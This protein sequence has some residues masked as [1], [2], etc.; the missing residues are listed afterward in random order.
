V[1][2]SL[3]AT[4]GE[5]TEKLE[6]KILLAF[7]HK[8]TTHMD[9]VQT[10]IRK[11]HPQ[12]EVLAIDLEALEEEIDRFK[13]HLVVAEPPVPENPGFKVPAWIELSIDPS[14]PS[15]FRVGQRQWESL[16]PGI[17]ELMAVVANTKKL[18]S[19]SS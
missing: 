4:V 5:N 3:L 8:H 7:Q 11:H 12:S 9:A 13:P 2:D 10:S 16:N 14:Q 18:M 1:Q 17:E 15:R 19:S 6:M